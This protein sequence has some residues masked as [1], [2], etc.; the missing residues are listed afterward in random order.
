MKPA[1]ACQRDPSRSETLPYNH[2][3]DIA[4]GQVFPN[5]IDLTSYGSDV[6]HDV[7]SGGI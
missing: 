6:N 7:V 1:C 5:D 3:T 2:D 4:R